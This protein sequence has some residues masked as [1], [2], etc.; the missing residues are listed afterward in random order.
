MAEIA[1]AG[2]AGVDFEKLPT[3][4]LGDVRDEPDLSA[5]EKDALVEYLKTF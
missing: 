1:V 5:E 2:Q 4:L 3:L